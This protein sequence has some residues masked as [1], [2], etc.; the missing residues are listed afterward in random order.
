MIKFK[1]S[2]VTNYYQAFRGFDND[3]LLGSSS[4]HNI[5]QVLLAYFFVRVQD[6]R[7]KKKKGGYQFY[8][9]S[10]YHLRKKKSNQIVKLAIAAIISL[11]D[12]LNLSNGALWRLYPFD[13]CF[14]INTL[15]PP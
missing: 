8:L 6:K 9:L 5:D 7:K 12:I 3:M 10:Y 2:S 11:V 1:G 14:K 15:L 4:P 13:I